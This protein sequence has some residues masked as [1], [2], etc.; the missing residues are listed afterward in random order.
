M[1]SWNE[2]ENQISEEVIFLSRN[3]IPSPYRQDDF[4]KCNDCIFRQIAILIVSGKIKMTKIVYTNNEIWQENKYTKPLTLRKQHGA[5]WHNSLIRIIESYFNQNKYKIKLEPDMYYGR[6][7]L[8]VPSLNLFIEVGT[9][10]LYKLYNNLINMADCRIIIV[11]ENNYL[12][13]FNL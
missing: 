9:I 10:N 7:D 3:I 11:P 4:I 12:I 1:P 2:I 13:E 8:G 5:S 6:A